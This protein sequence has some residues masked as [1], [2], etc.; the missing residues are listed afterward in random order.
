[1]LVVPWQITDGLGFPIYN[2][3]MSLWFLLVAAPLGVALTPQLGIMAFVFARLTGMLAFLFTC[4]M[5]TDAP[6]RGF[7][8]FFPAWRK[9]L[10][11]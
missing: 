5:C 6:S 1:M 9:F 8:L 2:A 3:L 11:F 7:S 4:S 10:L